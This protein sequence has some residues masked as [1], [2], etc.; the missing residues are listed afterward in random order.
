MGVGCEALQPCLAPVFVRNTDTSLQE[1][2]RR[3]IW[4]RGCLLSFPAS[5]QDTLFISFFSFFFLRAVVLSEV[6]LSSHARRREA[7]L[8]RE[9]Q[10]CWVPPR[11]TTAEGD[12]PED[13]VHGSGALSLRWKHKPLWS[14]SFSFLVPGMS[15]L[16][17]NML[18]SGQWPNVPAGEAGYQI[19]CE[20]VTW[21]PHPAEPWVREL[22]GCP[23]ASS[24]P[25]GEG[26]SLG[27]GAPRD[28]LSETVLSH[29]FLSFGVKVPCP[30][31]QSPLP[32]RWL[33]STREELSGG[34]GCPETAIVVLQLCLRPFEP[35]C[36]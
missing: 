9:L 35:L 18:N 36:V 10:P 33:H 32:A 3:V 14:Q 7:L 13:R 2:R 22:L 12:I 23:Q 17:Q 21:T 31:P 30:A 4:S 16:L 24:D 25:A 28:L 27:P 34:L 8:S 6:L 29:F 1:A 19:P 5:G 11:V 20:T 26:M 15:D